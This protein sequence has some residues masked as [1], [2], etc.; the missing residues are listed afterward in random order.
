VLEPQTDGATRLLLRSRMAFE[1]QLPIKLT[2]FV[3]F[4]M[5]R[6]MLLTIRDRAERL[7]SAP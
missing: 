7:A 2:Y 6:K 1:Q 4:I 5:E 3:Q